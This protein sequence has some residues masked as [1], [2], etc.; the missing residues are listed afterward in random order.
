MLCA[1][2]KDVSRTAEISRSTQSANTSGQPGSWC[3]GS[4]GA[5]LLGVPSPLSIEVSSPTWVVVSTRVEVVTDQVLLCPEGVSAGG[6][7]LSSL[8]PFDNV[9]ESSASLQFVTLVAILA[10]HV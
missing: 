3:V 10:V 9:L 2:V 7:L 5:S 1:R 6:A 8:T 4:S